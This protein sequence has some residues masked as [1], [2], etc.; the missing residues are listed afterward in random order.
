MK[1][2]NSSRQLMGKWNTHQKTIKQQVFYNNASQAMMLLYA[3]VPHSWVM[4]NEMELKATNSSLK[5]CWELFDEALLRYHS[6]QPV[7]AFKL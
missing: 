5:V 2:K 7:R 3:G 1:G 4:Y 6:T